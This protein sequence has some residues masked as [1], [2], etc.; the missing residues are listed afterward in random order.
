MNFYSHKGKL[1]I[2]HLK[3]VRDISKN[4]IPDELVKANNITS[5]CHD[6][7]KYTTYFQE[8]LFSKDKNKNGLSS[9]KNKKIRFYVRME[10]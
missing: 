9:F 1:I 8:Y 2:D 4:N 6:F 3:E 7:G 5:A 10:K